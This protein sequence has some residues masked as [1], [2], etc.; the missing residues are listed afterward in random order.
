MIIAESLSIKTMLQNNK[1]AK[2][3]SDVSWYEIHRQLEYKSKWKGR[4]YH[5]IDRFFP[6]S[7][8]CN[9]CHHINDKLTLKDRVWNCPNCGIQLDRDLNAS[10][11]ILTQ[12]LNTL[13]AVGITV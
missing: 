3:I 12:G 2:A 10:V 5:R 8:T 1:L 4:V 13:Q 6:S 7:K 11:N 9:S